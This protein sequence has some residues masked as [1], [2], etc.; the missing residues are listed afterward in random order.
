MERIIIWDFDGT[1]TPK[2]CIH[3]LDQLNFHRIQHGPARF[4]KKCQ[5]LVQVPIFWSLNKIGSRA[6]NRYFYGH[7]VYPKSAYD[8]LLDEEIVPYFLDNLHPNLEEEIEMHRSKGAR[9]YIVSA[10]PDILVKR[11]AEALGLDGY[12]ATEMPVHGGYYDG[13]LADGFID[14]ACKEAAVNDILKDLGL[15]RDSVELHVYGNSVNDLQMLR[16]ADHGYVVKPGGRLMLEAEKHGWNAI[17]GVRQRLVC[18]DLLSELFWQCCYPLLALFVKEYRGLHNIPKNRGAI[19]IAN[20]CSYLDHYVIGTAL[21]R[22]IAR[23]GHF[24]AKKEHFNSPMGRFI[25]RLLYAFPIDRSHFSHGDAKLCVRIIRKGGILIIYPEGTRSL[26]GQMH[27]FRKGFLA[28]QRLTKAPVVPIGLTN[29]FKALK[30]G[31]RIPR[32]AS[33][34]FRV[35]KPVEWSEVEHLT[36]EERI[37]L[38]RNRIDRLIDHNTH[39]CIRHQS[40]DSSG[41]ERDELV[42]PKLG[43]AC[44][45]V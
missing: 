43:S 39:K 35:G 27:E 32:S 8:R 30:K 9:Q 16:M 12:V 1:L 24:V 3:H 29:T 14:G 20:H 17:R 28:I 11:V 37:Q 41:P 26:D 23:Y 38:Y 15:S 40:A 7:L 10:S 4:L 2:N 44:E 31:S 34:R 25:H 5:L 42:K 13:R 6:F 21:P 33:I 18:P 22:H 36:E 19:L 45:G